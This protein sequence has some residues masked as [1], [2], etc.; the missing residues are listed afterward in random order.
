M[1]H[2]LSQFPD[3]EINLTQLGDVLISFS[4]LSIF[5]FYA[6]NLWKAL[7]NAGVLSLILTVF[8]KFLFKV[9]RPSAIIDT[10][11]FNVIGKTQCGNSSFPSGHSISIFFV[12]TIIS[13]AFLPQKKLYRIGWILFLLIIGLCFATTRVGVGAHF[14][15]DVL[16]GC[17]LGY[18]F[19]IFGIL[20][21]NKTDWLTFLFTKKFFPVFILLFILSIGILVSRIMKTHLLIYYITIISLTISIFI[22]LYESFKKNKIK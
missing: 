20:I 11:F 12:M 17:I 9:P 18:V 5:I 4:L 19:G 13:I 14:P 22:L 15:F 6:S 1:N 10:P 2:F 3:L 16:I 21:F 8:F 7:I